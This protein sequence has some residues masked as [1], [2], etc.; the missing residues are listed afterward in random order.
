MALYWKAAGGVLLAVVMILVLRRQE[1]G[2]LLC[3]C[4]C[5]MTAMAAVEYLDPVLELLDSLQAAGSMDTQMVAIL[6]KAVGIG[7]V[8]EIA[9]TVCADSGN[10]SLGKTLQLLGTA[11]VLWM[12]VPLFQALLEM[13]GDILGEL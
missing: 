10:A 5:A 9:C 1:M 13:T 4:V 2:L 7:L 3:V 12:A 6:L 8:T 11:V